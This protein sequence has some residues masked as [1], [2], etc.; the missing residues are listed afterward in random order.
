MRFHLDE[1]VA[2][3]IAAG[4]GRRGIDVTT[5]TDASLLL[6]PDEDHL[7]FAKR[8]GRVV[9][10][11]DPISCELRRSTLRTQESHF[12]PRANGRSAK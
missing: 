11:N 6:A 5:T 10:T 2:H 9:V 3:A 4:L 8:D 12:I 1:H 7:A